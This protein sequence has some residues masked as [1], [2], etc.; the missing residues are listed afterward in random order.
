MYKI[1]GFRKSVT[2]LMFQRIRLIRICIQWLQKV[3]AHVLIFQWRSLLL[4]DCR[5]LCI[6]AK[7]EDVTMN[8]M[9]I[10]YNNT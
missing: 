1:A 6:Y 7:F 10:V 8:R 3:S 2:G 5:F 4:V 9:Y